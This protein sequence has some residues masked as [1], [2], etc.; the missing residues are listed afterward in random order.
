MTGSKGIIIW[1]SILIIVNAGNAISV[2]DNTF[3]T[4]SAIVAT[5]VCIFMLGGNI[6]KRLE[7]KRDEEV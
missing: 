6:K 5:V 2:G 3:L 1:W 7:I 4:N